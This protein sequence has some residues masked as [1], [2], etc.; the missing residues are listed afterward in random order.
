M[1]APIPCCPSEHW[2]PAIGTWY[3]Q[4]CQSDSFNVANVHRQCV[5]S[6][7]WSFLL[8]S[9]QTSLSYRI[10][11]NEWH[12]RNSCAHSRPILRVG[13]IM[14]RAD[15]LEKPVLLSDA[16]SDLHGS[17]SKEQ[18]TKVSASGLTLIPQPSDDPKDPLV[19]GPAVF[20]ARHAAS[21]TR[22]ILQNWSISKKSI[23][24][25]IW[26]LGSFVSTA[27]GLGNALGYF[28]QAKVYH[29]DDPIDISYSVGFAHRP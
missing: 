24:T 27:S 21:L 5:I 29:K 9:E 10:L 20:R 19:S 6:R 11:R 13:I 15:P 17:S 7:G 28:V 1:L 12:A 8:T 4:V 2:F 23:T 22:Q 14:D 16:G 18:S 3:R 26:C 25:A